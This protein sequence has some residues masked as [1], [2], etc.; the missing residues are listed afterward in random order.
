MKTFLIL[1]LVPLFSLSCATH[2]STHYWT[3]GAGLSAKEIEKALKE[4]RIGSDR[5]IR[6][7]TLGSTDATSHH[8]VQIRS[9][10][11]LHI[12]KEHDLTV[13]IYRGHGT[14]TVGSRE[15][16][17]N[18]GD[19]LFVPRGIPHAFVNKSATPAIAVVVFTPGFDGTDTIPVSAKQ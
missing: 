17:V 14:M 11:A 15:I 16:D 13:F 19:I 12:H 3:S 2:H 6:I 8:I 1:L 18:R 5:D 7:V 9:A 10:E 4:N